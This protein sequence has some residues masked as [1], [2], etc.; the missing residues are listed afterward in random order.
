MRLSAKVSSDSA[1]DPLGLTERCVADVQTMR[2]LACLR[3]WQGLLARNTGHQPLTIELGYRHVQQQHLFPRR[4]F[5]GIQHFVVPVGVAYDPFQGI[6]ES[7]VMIDSRP[8][9]AA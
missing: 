6:A 2:P 7:T 4:G 9:P 1:A 3:G 8:L 5:A